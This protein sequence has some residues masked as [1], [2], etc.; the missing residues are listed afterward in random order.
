MGPKIN[1]INQ[2]WTTY[3]TKTSCNKLKLK[4]TVLCFLKL[5]TLHYYIRIG[6]DSLAKIQFSDLKI[7]C[8]NIVYTEHWLGMWQAVQVLTLCNRWYLGQKQAFPSEDIEKFVKRT[9]S[10]QDQVHPRTHAKAFHPS[11][12]VNEEGR[13]VNLSHNKVQ[14]T[15]SSR[16]RERKRRHMF[17]TSTRYKSRINKFHLVFVQRRQ[18][19][20]K[21]Q[22][23]WVHVLCTWQVAALPV[24]L[25][26]NYV[27][28]FT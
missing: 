4:P 27:G 8:P 13:T 28:L 17:L 2:P 14:A 22:N 7:Y 3:T 21:E 23:V 1:V 5:S 26:H 20:E 11:C 12:T 10:L 6:N 24:S 9:C 19:W 16:E 25:D 15:H 18:D